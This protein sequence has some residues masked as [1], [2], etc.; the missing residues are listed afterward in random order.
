MEDYSLHFLGKAGLLL[1]FDYHLD[2]IILQLSNQEI[3]EKVLLILY[4]IFSF[5]FFSALPFI[6]MK[7]FIR[8]SLTGLVLNVKV[9]QKK[10]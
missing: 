5:E 2:L 9:Y 4:F 8:I 10:F 3:E 7:R 6:L 1:H